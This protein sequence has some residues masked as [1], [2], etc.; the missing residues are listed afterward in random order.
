[1]KKVLLVDS[2]QDFFQFLKDKLALQQVS[3]EL[4][5][6]TRNA[7]TTLI[8][9]LPDLI[10]IDADSLE[11]GVRVFLEKKADD[12]N[13]KNIPILVI[14]SET[15]RHKICS[16]AVF[17]VH[18]FFPKPVKYDLFFKA[19]G[20]ILG[21]GF[22]A[23]QTQCIMEIH[24]TDSI[25]CVDIAGDLNR[26]K[27]AI[28]KYKI[29]QII[30]KHKISKPKLLLVLSGK[31]FDFIDTPNL[32][33]LL[34]TILHDRP[35]K[36]ENIKIV[37]K[38]AFFAALLKG[39]DEYRGIEIT[40]DA[41]KILNPL[42]DIIMVGEG[43]DVIIQRVLTPNFPVPIKTLDMRFSS[44][45]G[46]TIYSPVDEGNM[47]NV[48]IVDSDQ[49]AQAQLKTLFLQKGGNPYSY[50]SGVA[51]INDIPHHLFDV[52]ILDLTNTDMNGLDILRNLQRRNFPAPVII[53]SQTADKQNIMDAMQLGARTFLAKPTAPDIMIRTIYALLSEQQKTA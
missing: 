39:R 41:T 37:S 15:S 40:D 7:Y 14:G 4:A 9:I 16:L 47:L 23:D 29:P 36:K 38:D 12:P 51:F 21:L 19:V 33:F 2:T 20:E 22:E 17:G 11:G 34:E 28:L 45:Y 3:L 49:V 50:T 44:D 32:E 27:I 25:I 53:Y 10:I 43:K 24:V 13:A 52:V 8:T 46:D 26:D 35:I 48:A 6:S 18:K 30:Q 31:E 42:L 5:F 1:M